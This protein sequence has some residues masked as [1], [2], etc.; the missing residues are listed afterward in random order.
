MTHFYCSFTWLSL[1]S[2][3]SWWLDLLLDVH[4]STRVVALVLILVHAAWLL[5][6]LLATVV[7]W[8]WKVSLHSEIL[9][10]H[11]LVWHVLRGLVHQMLN[12]G[13]HHSW[14]W[15]LCFRNRSLILTE[16]VEI[17]RWNL[18]HKLLRNLTIVIDIE[19]RLANALDIVLYILYDILNVQIVLLLVQLMLKLHLL[20]DAEVLQVVLWLV[21]HLQHAEVVVAGQLLI[22][23]WSCGASGKTGTFQ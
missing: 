15:G 16:I 21:V 14:N 6:W 11:A 3:E 4:V 8:C 10:T 9:E 7:C 22:L 12:F 13:C 1:I 17:L 23:S 18:W 2:V 5:V 20:L 19:G